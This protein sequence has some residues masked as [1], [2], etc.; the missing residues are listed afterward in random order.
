MLIA[1]T[2]GKRRVLL[3]DR[4]IYGAISAFECCTV[5][6]QFPKRFKMLDE[7]HLQKSSKHLENQTEISVL[8]NTLLHAFPVMGR[9]EGVAGMS[10]MEES[11]KAVL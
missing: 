6:I 2:H 11:S 10:Q 8:E 5:C 7:I 1:S 9:T 4:N 3:V